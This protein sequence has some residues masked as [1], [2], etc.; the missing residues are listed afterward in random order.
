MQSRSNAPDN[1]VSNQT[2]E[3]KGEEV[4]HKQRACHLAECDNGTHA[5]CDGRDFT[6]GLLPWG[7]RAGLLFG[8]SDLRWCRWRRRCRGRGPWDGLKKSSVVRDEG[9]ANYL[10]VQVYMEI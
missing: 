3:T 6:P 2:G 5:C 7:D 9:T 10:V 1:A 4:G 8:C